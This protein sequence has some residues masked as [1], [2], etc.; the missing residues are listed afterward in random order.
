[1]L[2]P[3]CGLSLGPSSSYLPLPPPSSEES[4][5]G[6][7]SYAPLRLPELPSSYSYIVFEGKYLDKLGCLLF[8]D[9]PVII[10][11]ILDTPLFLEPGTLLHAQGGSQVLVDRGLYPSVGDVILSVAGVGVGH[12]TLME[13]RIFIAPSTL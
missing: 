2:C 6:V 12:L 5:Q 3:Q 7:F 9:G 1:M 4:S 11:K 13:V 8:G 10:A